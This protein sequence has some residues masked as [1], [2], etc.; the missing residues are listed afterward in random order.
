MLIQICEA[1]LGLCFGA[2]IASATVAFII[3]LGIVPRYAGITKSANRIMLYEDCS[4]AGAV[5]GSA[6][7]VFGFSLPVGTAGLLVFG[8]LAGIF[9]GSWVV[10]LGEIVNI[11]SIMQRRIG[12]TRG[13]GWVVISIALGKTLGSLLF[14]YKGWW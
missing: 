9:L 13:I 14:F 11:Y 7:S 4:M 8:A 2:V 3:S 5:L 10:A 12:L 1:L 6:F